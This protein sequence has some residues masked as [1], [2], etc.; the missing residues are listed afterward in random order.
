MYLRST[1]SVLLLLLTSD[2]HA[3]TKDALQPWGTSGDWSVF[4]D[5]AVGNGCLIQK[6]FDEGFRIRLGYVPDRKGGF[7]AALSEE[8]GHVEP[9]SKGLVRFISDKDK[10]AGEAEGIE[11][12]NMRG[13]WAFFNNPE[14]AEE[15]ARRR[16]ITVIGPQGGEFDIDLTGSARAIQEAQRCQSEQN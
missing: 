8:W 4:V 5:P 10:F 14:F 1:L 15:L 2:L 3:D 11:D 7:F 12:G 13:G 9:G 16:S 6:D